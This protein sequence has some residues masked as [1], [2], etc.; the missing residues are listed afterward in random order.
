MSKNER[1]KVMK[2]LTS[3]ILPF[4][5]DIRPF[6]A[7]DFNGEYFNFPKVFKFEEVICNITN[8]NAH[9]RRAPRSCSF[10]SLSDNWQ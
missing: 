8:A 3:D 1:E 2:F 9:Q 5:M 6:H 7:S 4:F 10:T